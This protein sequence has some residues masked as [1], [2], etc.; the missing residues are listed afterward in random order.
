MSL[1]KSETVMAGGALL[2][3]SAAVRVHKSPVAASYIGLSDSKLR[4]MRMVGQ[5]P[6]WVVLSDNRVGYLQA[7]LDDWI[8]SRPK[9]PAT[10][11]ME[12]A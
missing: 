7:D 5:G 4:K 6:R 8:N 2:Q 1:S 9:M 10:A 11:Q 3:V 12:A